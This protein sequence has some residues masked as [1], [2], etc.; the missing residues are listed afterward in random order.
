MKDL[1]ELMGADHDC[2]PSGGELLEELAQL[3]DALW[4]ESI[5]RFIKQ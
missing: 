3:R 2:V 1:T 4:I 5:L